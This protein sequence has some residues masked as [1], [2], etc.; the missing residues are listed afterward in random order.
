[1]FYLEKNYAGE[2][3][4]HAGAEAPDECCG[5]LAGA[6]GKVVKL[7]RA[8]NAAHSPFRYNVHPEEL[9]GIYRDLEEKK[10]DLLGIY[11][12]HTASPAYPSA[13]D[14]RYAFWSKALYII[15]SLQNPAK[16][17]LRAFHINKGVIVEEELKIID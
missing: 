3:A 5:I 15:I 16:P 8:A 2:M 1:L 9:L 10:W 7:Y 6:G 13:V 14:V 17:V 12:S 4:A 11:H